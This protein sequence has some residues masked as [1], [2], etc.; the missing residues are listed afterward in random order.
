M[1]FFAW[2]KP[3]FVPGHYGLAALVALLLAV[4]AA[5]G[6]PDHSKVPGVII[7]YSPA[8][9]RQY[10]GSPSIAVLPGGDFVASH[11]FFGPG[12]TKDKSVVFRS[13][14]KGKSWQKIADI[15]GQWWSTLFVHQGSLYLMGTS[16]EYGFTVIRKSADGGK[17]WTT[18]KDAGSGLLLGDG[19]YHCAPVPVVVHQG[20]LW[21]AMEDAMGPGGW[22][23]HFRAFMMSAPVDAD[24]LQAKSWTSSN[25]LGRDPSWLDGKFGGW[26]EGNAV[27]DRAG[28][29][30]AMAWIEHHH[31]LGVGRAS[32]RLR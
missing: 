10:I 24:L 1:R 23:S 12:S 30:A 14:D 9:T 26:L 19:K 21:R 22:G 8:S 25:R 3:A 5:A 18:P 13:R 27:A 29:D 15:D 6:Q 20:R 17:T 4:G 16:K 11:D 32:R 7:D 2:M 28:I 31:R